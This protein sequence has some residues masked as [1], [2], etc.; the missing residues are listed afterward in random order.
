LTRIVAWQH[1]SIV[2]ERF[3]SPDV[4]AALEKLG[5]PATPLPKVLGKKIDVE[6]EEAVI[7]WMKAFG[8]APLTDNGKGFRNLFRYRHLSLW[9]WAEIFLYHDTPLRLLVRDIE[10]LARLLEKEKPDRFVV[11]APTRNLAAAARHL[12]EQVEV[13]GEAAPAS[14]RYRAVPFLFTGALLKM[15][16]TGLKGLARRSP[17]PPDRRIGYLFL[18]H[19]SMWRQRANPETG[20]QE[21][22]DIYFDKIPRVLA[23]GGDE[24][25]LVAVGPA[26]AFR[27]RGFKAWAQ[28]VLEL[29]AER[30]AYVSIRNYFAPRLSL[31][32]T[33]AAWGCWKMWRRFRSLPRLGEALTHRGVPLGEGSLESFRDSFFLQLPWAIRSYHEIR[34]ALVHERPGL[35]VLYA[36]SSGLGRAAIAAAHE[37]SIPTAAI[38]HGIMYPRYYSHE[39]A[40]DEVQPQ[41][42][43]NESVPIPLRTT[44][45]GSFAY[46]LLVDRGHYPSEKVVITGSP[47]FDALVKVASRFDTLAT[48]RRL[49]IDEKAPLLVVATRYAAMGPVFEELVRACDAIPELW[50]AAKPH[51]AESPEPY[52]RVVTRVG[53][54]RARVVAGTENLLELLVASNGLVTVD[55]LASSEALAI[56]RPVVVVNLPSNLEPLVERGVAL[57][58]WR[59]ESI[60]ER[61]RELLFD[62]EVAAKLETR[63]KECIQEFAFGAEGGST[64]RI[65]ETLREAA[66]LGRSLS[67]RVREEGE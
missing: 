67:E 57:G 46:D 61:L 35:L 39:H 9:W 10:V 13:H 17:S 20:E 44:V 33:S 49:G 15:V 50:L 3:P 24:V 32:L 21:R 48:R 11:V 51:Q 65:V 42:D 7:A 27:Q 55:S 59:G 25:K 58:V 14:S 54:S 31:V 26:V 45:F 34:S 22:L 1:L 23:A 36:E 52:R 66:N 5:I 53:A 47:R 43:G 29:G 62:P 30:H 63:R 60:E 8:R 2:L 64:E 18:T 4:A 12:A 6:A 37:L 40:V 56:G 41:S 19:A 16:G 38:Q 28:D